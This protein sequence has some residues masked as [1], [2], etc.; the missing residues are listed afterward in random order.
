MKKYM[1]SLLT[2]VDNLVVN[3]ILLE[4]LVNSILSRIAPEATA[5]AGCAGAYC[6]SGRKTRTTCVNGYQLICLWDVSYHYTS[7]GC[8]CINWNNAVTCS[9]G[10]PC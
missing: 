10:S 3:H 6:Y 2:Q 5:Y 7:W 9:G 8:S 4:R 1:D